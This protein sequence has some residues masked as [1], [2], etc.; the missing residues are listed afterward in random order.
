MKFDM[1]VEDN[2]NI[3]IYIYIYV[4]QHHGFNILNQLKVIE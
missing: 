3:Y 4:I 1:R 2:E